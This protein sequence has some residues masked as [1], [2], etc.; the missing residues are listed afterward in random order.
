MRPEDLPLIVDAL[1]AYGV[2]WFEDPADANDVDSLARI[3]TQSNLPVVTGETLYSKQQF[4]RLLEHK[5]V[6]ILNPDITLCGILG[7][8]EIAAIAEAY[9]TN[10]SVH[11]NNTMTIGLAAAMQVAAVI[12]NFTLVEYF[13]RFVKGS[14]TFS[15]FPCELDEDGCIPLSDEPGLGVAVDEA[16]VA[17]MEFKP[18]L[19]DR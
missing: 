12:P 14:N 5:A 2:P 7:T 18:V 17:A 13:P 4:L 8:K 19:D 16:T 3:R 15:S 6:D 10:V 9:S 11:N 1:H